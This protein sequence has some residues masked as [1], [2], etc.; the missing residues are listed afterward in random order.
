MEGDRFNMTLP[1]SACSADHVPDGV[2]QRVIQVT[3]L[4]TA[5]AHRIMVDL[6]Q[7]QCP[8]HSS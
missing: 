4:V 7:I 3:P 8:A 5:F 2:R 1:L 6:V